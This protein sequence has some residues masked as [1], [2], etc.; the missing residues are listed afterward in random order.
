M[1]KQFS[2]VETVI[3]HWPDPKLA[4]KSKKPVDD[5]V[6]HLIT[7]S[8]LVIPIPKTTTTIINKQEGGNDDKFE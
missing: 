8:T 5:N 4:L 1:I 2:V 6:A 3:M 7:E